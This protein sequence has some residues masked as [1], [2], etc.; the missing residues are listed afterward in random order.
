MTTFKSNV[1]LF[2]SYDGDSGRPQ[3]TF[4][5]S[6]EAQK[7]FDGKRVEIKIVLEKKRKDSEKESGK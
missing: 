1:R 4:Y 6:P 7:E 3:L 5:V 2:A